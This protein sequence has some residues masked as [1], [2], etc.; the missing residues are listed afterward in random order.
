MTRFAELVSVSSAVAGTGSRKAKTGIMSELISR[1]APGERRLAVPML[2]GSLRQGRVG[3]GYA[4]V[5]GGNGFEAAA[6]ASLDIGDVDR[7]MSELQSATGE[8]SQ[9]RRQRILQSLLNK[10]TEPEQEYIGRLLVGEVR[11]GALQGLVL[12]AVAQASGCPPSELRR[13]LML[14]PDLGEVA[15][16]AMDG[17]LGSPGAAG[18]RP[19]SPILPMLAST[20]ASLEEALTDAASV[21]WKLD[22]ARVQVHRLGPEVA[23][24][25]RNLRDVTAHM[26]ELAAEALALPVESVVLDG[27][28]LSLAGDGRPRPF[29][30]TMSRFGTEDEGLAGPGLVPYFFDCLFLDGISLIDRPLLE[31]YEALDRAV[32]ERLRIPRLLTDSIAEAAAFMER[33]LAAGHEGV[34]VKSPASVYAAG[35]RGREWR[36]VKPVLTFDLVVLAAEWGHGR[37]TGYLSNL[38]L[39]A[40]DPAG[41]PPV[42]VGKTFKGMTDELLAWQ[43]AALQEIETRRTA[44]TVWVKPELVVEVALD[45]VQS[46]TRYP[47]GVALRFARIRGYR[48]DKAPADADTIDS[49]LDLLRSER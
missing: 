7:A 10:A 3:V 8:G 44:N 13:A 2:A 17:D 43:T 19:L 9:G 25:T 40:R 27:E 12:E 28:A 39:G 32:P 49:L 41:G 36:K 38:H 33:G 22:G 20:A 14:N 11:H 42:M 23:V 46:S 35:R 15:E 30:E 1:L 5:W 26:P 16:L 18:L 37:R 31:R 48:P 24:F 21:E 6:K 47:G 29:Q 34:M 4:S 45:G